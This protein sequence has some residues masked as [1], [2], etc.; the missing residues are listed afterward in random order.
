MGEA[1]AGG[2]WAVL[3]INGA[4][5]RAFENASLPLHRLNISSGVEVFDIWAGS[6]LK[7]PPVPRG[8]GTFVFPSV[9]PRDSGFYTLTPTTTD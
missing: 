4:P 2:G 5:N 7:Q 9:A 3:A 8:G 1:A 6:S